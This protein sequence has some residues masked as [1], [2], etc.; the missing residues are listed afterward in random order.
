MDVLLGVLLGVVLSASVFAVSRLLAPRRVL[1]PGEEGV[2]A[3]LHAAAATLPHLRKGL[4]RESAGKAI[5]HLHALTQAA[6]VL[7]DD[8]ETVLAADGLPAETRH[9]SLKRDCPSLG[10]ALDW[11]PDSSRVEVHSGPAPF[12]NTVVA[13]LMVGGER[14]GRLAAFYGPERRLR[15]EDTRVVS[16]VAALVSAQVELSVL[17]EQEERLAQAELR[18][19]RAQISPHFIYNALAAVAN[20]IHTKP[21]EA[22]ELLTEFAEFT[23]YAFRGNRSYVTL[24]D[25]LHYVEKYL[26]LE[27][28]RF[29]DRLDVRVSVAPE[30]LTAVVPVLSM[31]PLVENAVRHG[32][33]KAVG[34]CRVEILGADLDTDVE[35]T[36]RDG[37]A[38]MDAEAADAALHGRA[39][40]IGL[41][42]VHARLQSTFG[43]EYGLEV[44]STPGQGTVVKMLVPK[45]RAG[46]R[47]A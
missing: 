36:V 34:P 1:A 47:A 4:T 41:A 10:N 44:E 37:G 45:F 38:G 17:A 7:I 3:A 14:I 27:Q 11:L 19:L 43:P 2:R 18:A 20:S 24:A 39:G 25:E 42:N 13:P 5:G 9:V 31:Q 32:V 8:G 12:G 35:L 46:V 23:R 29:G 16:E 30:V 21:E 15:P 26:R 33:E 22:R 6:G 40:G 28:A